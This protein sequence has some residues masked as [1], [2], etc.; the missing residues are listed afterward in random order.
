VQVK[1]SI[2]EDIVPESFELEGRLLFSL[3]P[4]NGNH[5]AENRQSLRLAAR[6]IAG[7][8][9]HFTY[10]RHEEL[11]IGHPIQHE[12]AKHFLGV[13]HSVETFSCLVAQVDAAP[14]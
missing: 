11:P 12:S 7:V 2:V 10:T 9:K 13:N 3:I 5:L 6:S 1:G 8:R 4:E 14:L